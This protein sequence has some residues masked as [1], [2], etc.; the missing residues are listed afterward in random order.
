MPKVDEALSAL[1]AFVPGVLKERFYRQALVGS[2][3]SK[4]LNIPDVWIDNILVYFA[5]EDILALRRTCKDYYFLTHEPIIWKRFLN[6]MNFPLPP[7]RPTLRYSMSI[8][9]FEIE[10]LVTQAITVDDN[11]RSSNP[12]IFDKKTLFTGMVVN[13]LF[14]VPG[15]RFLLASLMDRTKP[16]RPG[17]VKC[18]LYLYILDHPFGPH[19]VCRIE[20]FTRAYNLRAKFC[21]VRRGE[22]GMVI[23]Y[24]RR[25]PKQPQPKT[26]F[27]EDFSCEFEHKIDIPGGFDYNIAVLYLNMNL[28]EWITQ[29]DFNHASPMYTQLLRGI[30]NPFRELGMA[31]SGHEFTQTD[32]IYFRER[33][34]LVSINLPHEVHFMNIMNPKEHTIMICQPHSEYRQAAYRIRAFRV[35]PEQNDMVLIRTCCPVPGGDEIHLVEW[36]PLPQLNGVVQVACTTRYTFTEK[37]VRRFTISDLGAPNRRKLYMDHPLPN[38]TRGPPPPVSIYIETEDP[39][40][41][42]HHSIFPVQEWH[43]PTPEKP[44]GWFSYKFNHTSYCMSVHVC[45]PHR[46]KILPGS[47][48]ALMCVIK[49]DDKT[50]TP[51]LVNI[52]RYV[53]PEGAGHEYF[54]DP[55][56]KEE[57]KEFPVTRKGGRVPFKPKGVYK[58]F[59]EAGELVEELNA[60]GGLRAIAWDEST[61]RICIASDKKDEIQILDTAY[62][63]LPDGNTEE[64]RRR[65]RWLRHEL[66]LQAEVR[67]SQDPR[68][69]EKA[70][71]ASVPMDVDP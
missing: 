23:T 62:T 30:P 53:P 63:K 60:Q 5:V 68:T 11:W 59:A 46:P 2:P 15:G 27:D 4:I 16:K 71:Q 44:E 56:V 18:F 35:Y 1:D 37:K 13:D 52:K 33:H 50:A 22:D 14:L 48:R 43:I 41:V 31:N 20:T 6:R 42:Q 55:D 24:N 28:V 65:R 69:Y 66:E 34:W 26:L 49:G 54:P 40:G 21:R 70:P 61:G 32:I 29:P 3:I 51:K 58:A 36:H 47:Q 8:A 64:W 57:D 19:A 12:R 9:D 45:D 17:R 7:F 10:Q 39:H 67:R 25:K 38:H